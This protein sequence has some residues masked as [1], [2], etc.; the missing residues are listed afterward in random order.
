MKIYLTAIIKS[1]PE[2]LQEVKVILE[3]MVFHTSNESACSQYKL[4]QILE[5]VTINKDYR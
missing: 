4:H 2:F 3:N 1:K 5:I